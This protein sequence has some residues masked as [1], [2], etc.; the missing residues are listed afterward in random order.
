SACYRNL[1]TSR[2]GVVFRVLR[3]SPVL[4]QSLGYSPS[5]LKTSVYALRAFP[6]GVAGCLFGYVSLIVEPTS[7]GL[8]LGIGIVAASV[9]G[10]T[11][12]VYGVLIGAALLQL[13]PEK[14]ISFAQYAP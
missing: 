5:K 13:G 9:L 3:E 10:G 7:F 1:V 4:T 8:T 14:S 12:S 6:A 11:E 2:F